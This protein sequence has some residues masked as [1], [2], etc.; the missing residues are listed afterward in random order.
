MR[1]DE[2]AIGCRRKITER[3]RQHVKKH[4]DLLARNLVG[5]PDSG[6]IA[7]DLRAPPFF[8][9][10]ERRATVQLFLSVIWRSSDSAV[11]AQGGAYD[12]AT[13]SRIILSYA[14]VQRV[15]MG[16]TLVMP[17][18]RAR[19]QDCRRHGDAM[20][21]NNYA[22]TRP[23]DEHIKIWRYMSFTK[24]IYLLDRSALYFGRVD[25]LGDPFEGSF[26]QR[27][28]SGELRPE[29]MIP[30]FESMVPGSKRTGWHVRT[31]QER[32]WAYKT[33]QGST[34]A[35]CWHMNEHESAAMWSVYSRLGEGIAIQSTYHRLRDSFISE[36]HDQRVN[37]G[38]VT[39][40]DYDV[41]AVPESSLLYPYLFKRKSYE[42][43][44]ELRALALDDAFIRERMSGNTNPVSLP[45]KIIDVDLGILIESIHVSPNS[46]EWFT[47]LVRS[48]AARQP[49]KSEIPVVNSLL[50]RE[51]LH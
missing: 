44:R 13:D 14:F 47:E 27:N 21:S 31:T 2:A 30:V 19:R 23:S 38:I 20:Y 41:D 33:G 43:E 15:A 25:K 4:L 12:G 6:L 29:E 39:Y 36:D 32:E 24:F 9:A 50:D 42:H 18:F 7:A 26:G 22:C 10:A 37:I 51:P 48:M 17:L 34:F 3:D 35:N 11:V 8:P 16:A 46:P 40:V 49:Q 5:R 45:G 1:P 28:L